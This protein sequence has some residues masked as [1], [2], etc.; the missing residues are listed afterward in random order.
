MQGREGI[1]PYLKYDLYF[2]IKSKAGTW[3]KA[4]NLKSINSAQLDYCPFVS[5][6]GKHFFFT[7]ERHALPV[8]F[9]N[10]RAT[11]KDLNDISH[12]LLNGTGNIYWIDF[13]K[14]LESVK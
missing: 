8:S 10:S 2:S 1:L 3:Q 6:D 14:V 13:Q 9:L 4:V 11:Y 7:S 12:S 5:M